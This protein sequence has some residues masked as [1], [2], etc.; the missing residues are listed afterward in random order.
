MCQ[1][2][3]RDIQCLGPGEARAGGT[4]SGTSTTTWRAVQPRRARRAVAGRAQKAPRWMPRAGYPAHPFGKMAG[5]GARGRLDRLPRFV[6]DDHSRPVSCCH[7]P[8]RDRCN[9]L[10]TQERLCERGGG[11]AGIAEPVQ[12]GSRFEADHV[13]DSADREERHAPVRRLLDARRL[14]LDRHDL[15]R[16]RCNRGFTTAG[17]AFQVGNGKRPPSFP[18]G[19][20]RLCRLSGGGPN[21]RESFV[22]A[23]GLEPARGY[24]PAGALSRSK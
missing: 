10:G 9:R 1:S 17:F 8:P 3:R 24:A 18:K 15:A 16:D 5:V 7:S 11:L 13:A 22:R 12:S 14:H 2:R 4:S 21:R 19:P 6:L 23:A 20:K